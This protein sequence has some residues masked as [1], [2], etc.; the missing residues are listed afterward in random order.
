MKR[1]LFSQLKVGRIYYEQYTGY[2]DKFVEFDGYSAV[3]EEN[4]FFAYKRCKFY[5]YIPD[6]LNY[7]SNSSIDYPYLISV[8]LFHVTVK[9]NVSD[10]L[11]GSVNDSLND[12]NV[13]SNNREK[14]LKELEKLLGFD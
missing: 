14:E 5:E 3:F 2:R 1:V 11:S 8:P 9:S 4:I 10:S 12:S 6:L 7:Y 13:N